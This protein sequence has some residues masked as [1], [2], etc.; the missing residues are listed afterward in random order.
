MRFRPA[1]KQRSSERNSSL[2]RS[3]RTQVS[4]SSNSSPCS[5]RPLR[6]CR[7][8]LSSCPTDGRLTPALYAFLT[9]AQPFWADLHTLIVGFSG[10][11][12]GEKWVEPVDPETARAI[13]ALFISVLFSGRTAKN[14]GLW[15][16]KLPGTVEK[17]GEHNRR[18]EMLSI[19]NRSSSRREEDSANVT[20]HVV[21][22]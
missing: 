9:H 10:G 2:P 22:S 13:C 4:S 7:R 18:L 6:A 16:P 8:P 19:T 3:P 17:P 5:I 20:L 11:A 1:S 14:F 21:L 12:V 15:N